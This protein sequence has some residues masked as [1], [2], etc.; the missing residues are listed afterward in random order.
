MGRRSKG[1]KGHARKKLTKNPR[2][3]GQTPV[4]RSIQELSVGSKVAI[5]ID[6]GVV[7]GQPHQRYHGRI[8]VVNRKMGRAYVV[9]FRDGGKT[10]RVISAPEHLKLVR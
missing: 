10:K 3:R 2:D 1:I 8:G 9:E 4:S 7:G 5:L 6:S